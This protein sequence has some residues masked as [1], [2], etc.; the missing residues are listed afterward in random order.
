MKN[1]L[2]STM[3]ITATQFNA[4]ELEQQ[5]YVEDFCDKVN[6]SIE[7]LKDFPR[8]KTHIKDI[9]YDNNFTINLSFKSHLQSEI[10]STIKEDFET[11]NRSLMKRKF[12]RFDY[13]EQMKEGLVINFNYYNQKEELITNFSLNHESCKEANSA[14]SALKYNE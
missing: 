6:C 7:K 2:L 1:L 5:K 10:T 9:S 4:D 3:L 14:L 12:C 11:M 13:F 8:K